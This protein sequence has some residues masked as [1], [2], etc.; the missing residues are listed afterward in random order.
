VRVSPL[1]YFRGMWSNVIGQ[2]RIKGLLRG[3]LEREKLPG[4]YLFYGPEGVGKDA[5]AFELAKA[6]NCLNPQEN[7][8]A[9]CDECASCTAIDAMSSPV[10]TFVCAVP[11]APESGPKDDDIDA[12]REQL[13]LKAADKYHN[14]EIPR[15]LLIN[16]EQIRELRMSLSRSLSGGKRRIVIMTEADKMNGQAQNAFLKTLEEPHQNT[17]LILTS[18]NPHHL[19]PTILSRCQDVRFDPLGEEEIADALV[20]RDEL[21]RT[22][23][24]FLA[25][26]AAG[27]YSQAREMI[28]EDIHEMRKEIVAFLRMG[29]SQNRRN[30]LKEIDGF[31]PRAGGGKYLEKR[32]AVEQRLV[33]LALWLRDALAMTTD[34]AERI[35]NLDQRED[36]EK[37]VARFGQPKRIIRAIKA[38]ESAHSQARM[39]LQLRPVMINLVLELE[40]A[41][42]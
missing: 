19:Y 15:A 16:V 25:R 10:V 35:I 38:V 22:Q 27:S 5:M 42:L 37:F 41:L 14:I 39:Q 28:G 33:L 29:L 11:K 40:T 23:A 32:A 18:S 12:I 30:A 8:T 21:E 31:V 9:A 3:V 34:S 24:E 13:A 26:L 6:V 17:I 1:P 36:L 7:G 20:S 4:S 2:E